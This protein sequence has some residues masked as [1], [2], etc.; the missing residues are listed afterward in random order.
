MKFGAEA[1]SNDIVIVVC[2]LI[3]RPGLREGL[4]EGCVG[5]HALSCFLVALSSLGRRR[6]RPQNIAALKSSHDPKIRQ[7]INFNTQSLITL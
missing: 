3:L 4:S 6:S 1:I 7:D 2:F 5:R